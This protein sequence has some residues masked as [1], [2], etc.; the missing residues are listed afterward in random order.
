MYK[1]IY[2][3]HHEGGGGG[4]KFVDYV[5]VCLTQFTPLYSAKWERILPFTSAQLEGTK[6]SYKE[7]PLTSPVIS[8]KAF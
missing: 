6:F 7:I 3:P 8:T 5:V 4:V 1:F 2:Y